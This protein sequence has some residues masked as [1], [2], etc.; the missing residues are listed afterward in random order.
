MNPS[1][2]FAK[3]LPNTVYIGYDGNLDNPQLKWKE[4]D[5]IMGEPV[6][7]TAYLHLCHLAEKTLDVTQRVRYCNRIGHMSDWPVRLAALVEVRG[8]K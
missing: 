8:L 2:V 7:E 5:E 3:L 6:A 1:P 4:T